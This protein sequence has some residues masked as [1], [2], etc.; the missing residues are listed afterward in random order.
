MTKLSSPMVVCLIWFGASARRLGAD[1][2]LAFNDRAR[3]RHGRRPRQFYIN[4]SQLPRQGL[5]RNARAEFRN[6]S[7]SS[8]DVNARGAFLISLT[9]DYDDA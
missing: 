4:S 5:L 6:M 9:E 7:L 3:T 2:P 1:G 8:E